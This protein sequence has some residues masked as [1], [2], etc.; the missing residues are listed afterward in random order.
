[1]LRKLLQHF[2]LIET[3]SYMSPET[4]NGSVDLVRAT[5]PFQPMAE[6]LAFMVET[7]PRRW[8]KLRKVIRNLYTDILS[9]ISEAIQQAVCYTD[10]LMQAQQQDPTLPQLIT[11]HLQYIIARRVV[12]KILQRD[13][14]AFAPALQW[15]KSKQC[16]SRLLRR[17]QRHHQR[18][19]YAK[20]RN[21][22][23][24]LFTLRYLYVIAQETWASSPKNLVAAGECTTYNGFTALSLTAHRACTDPVYVQCLS[25]TTARLLWDTSP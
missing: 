14:N 18:L 6:N 8:L 21:T 7:T 3:I 9:L 16:P 2:Q 20:Q 24:L 4:I 5:P 25:C 13:I 15:P 23:V 10:E 11:D 12:L 19:S 1:M 17:S 22:D